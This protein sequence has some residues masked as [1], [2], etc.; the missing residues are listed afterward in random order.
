M[1]DLL[2]AQKRHRPAYCFRHL[3]LELRSQAWSHVR[4]YG[5]GGQA[6]FAASA[7]LTPGGEW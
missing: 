5:G 6:E 7:T 2:L 1:Q 3:D 4:S